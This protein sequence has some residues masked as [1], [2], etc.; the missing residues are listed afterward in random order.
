MPDKSL[1]ANKWKLE[2]CD[3][4][5]GSFKPALSLFKLSVRLTDEVLNET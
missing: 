2:N 3:Q 4:K 1:C 5:M